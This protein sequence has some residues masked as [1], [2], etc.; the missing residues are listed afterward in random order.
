MTQSDLHFMQISVASVSLVDLRGTS[1]RQAVQLE[2][3]GNQLRDRQVEG[4]RIREMGQ[5]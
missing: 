2:G 4:N 1:Q 3:S 5:D